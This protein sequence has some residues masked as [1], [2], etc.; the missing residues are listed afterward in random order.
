M[1]NQPSH[2]FTPLSGILKH[3]DKL[4]PQTLKKRHLVFFC[5]E[6]WPKYS[7]E[8]GVTWPSEKS[9]N[10]NIIMQL[11]LFYRQEGKWSEVL[12]VQAFFTLR[13]HPDLCKKCRVDPAL[14]AMLSC[15]PPPKETPPKGTSPKGTPPKEPPV[16]PSSP[17]ED[18]S[19]YTHLLIHL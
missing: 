15:L 9:I 17:E 19:T 7:L 14:L 16:G 12:Y 5:S 18:P 1:G 8:D 11:D 2:A 10:Y 4:D 6:V 3:W 13:D